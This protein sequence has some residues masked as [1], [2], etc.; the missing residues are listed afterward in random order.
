MANHTAAY[1]DIVDRLGGSSIGFDEEVVRNTL[2]MSDDENLHAP[3][4]TE[5]FEKFV[6]KKCKDSLQ[7]YTYMRL[8]NIDHLRSIFVRE[9]DPE[10]LLILVRTFREQVIENKNFNTTEEQLF[11]AQFMLILGSTPGFDYVLE[12]LQPKELEQIMELVLKRLDKLEGHEEI[13]IMDDIRATF[14]H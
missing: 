12:F 13:R 2:N 6:G 1:Q 4:N 7:R 3:K 8:V 11:V 14:K 9:L 5:E 10:L